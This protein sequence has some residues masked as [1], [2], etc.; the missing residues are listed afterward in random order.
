MIRTHSTLR[1]ALGFT[2]IAALAACD[3]STGVPGAQELSILFTVSTPAA[4]TSVAPTAS[5]ASIVGP[6]MVLTGPNGTLTIDEIRLVVAE[7]ELE[8][9]DDACEDAVDDDCN[10]VEAPPRF[11]DLPLD[12][13]PV[14]AITGIIPPGIYDELE[15]EVED[16]EDDESDEE[17]ADEIT[18]LRQVILAEFPEWPE[19]ASAMV[20]GTF[21]TDAGSTP[22]RVFI[23]AEIEVE[24]DL[25]P[26]LVV[27]GT[28]TTP[29][30][31]TID[32]QPDRWFVQ[33]DG[34]LLDLSA[35]DWATTGLLLELEV[36][37]EDG[38]VEVEVDDD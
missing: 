20:A 37:I 7:V 29:V 27:D 21:A 3:D 22:F 10:E 30:S 19:E 28:E 13:Q 4:P 26:P 6:P 1:A 5:V 18:T 34:S 38:F 12:G 15:F 11:L 31:L 17:F 14:E 32:V 2:A 35:Y 25:D 16:L 8:G 36:E 33:N 23:E 24:M 9:D